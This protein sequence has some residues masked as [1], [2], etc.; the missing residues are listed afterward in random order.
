MARYGIKTD[1]AFGV[2]VYELR[3][4]AKGYRRDH[5]L[6]LALWGTGNHEARL[7]ASMVDD[8]AQ[9]TEEQME[10]WAGDFDSWDVC[11]QVTSNLFDKTP[12]AYDKVAEWSGRRGRVGQAG[13]V[14]DGGRPGRPGQEGG[15]RALLA[16][17]RAHPARGRRRPQLREEGRQLGAAQHRQAQRGAARGGDR[18]GRGDPRRR[19]TPSPPPTAATRPRAAAAGSPATP[20]AS[21]APRRSS[22]ASDARRAGPPRAT[23]LLWSPC[24]GPAR[25]HWHGGH[26]AV[27]GRTADY[28]SF[29]RR[30]PRLVR[31]TTWMRL[32]PVVVGVAALVMIVAI[33]FLDATVHPV[34]MAGF[35]L[36]PL[37]LLALSARERLVLVAGIICAL[38]I[39]ARDGPGRERST[40][41]TASACST[42]GSRA[43]R[44]WSSPT[45]SAGCPR[46]ATTPPCGPSSPRPAPTSSPA[47]ARVTTSTSCSSTRS[48]GSAS[49]STPPAAW[50]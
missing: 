15:R 21:C 14:R 1:D 50:C 44:S 27:R 26:V 35:Y 7:L 41:P 40:R 17:P 24:A 11:D 23:V 38:L 9:V 45:S 12:F 4:I 42:A 31:R 36:I 20:C 39:A 48:S 2:S 33:F 3:R 32:H 18:D 19:P 22:A 6:A 37:T 46:S 47:A 25:A 29:E 34:T 10:S 13:G 8:P 43:S 16:H 49:S 30:H 5:E 28:G